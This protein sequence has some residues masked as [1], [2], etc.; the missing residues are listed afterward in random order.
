[1]NTCA[2]LTFGLEPQAMA[3]LHMLAGREP[4]FARWDPEF[5]HYDVRIETF[6]WYNGRERGIALVVHRNYG[7]SGPCLILTFGE[8][9]N[10][11]DIFVEQWEQD[12]APFN[13]PTIENRSDKNA[14][15][16]YYNR[17]VCDFGNIGKAAEHIIEAMAEWYNVEEKPTLKALPA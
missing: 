8:C 14:A 13:C 2:N 11:D 10:S 17:W 7:C 5:K 9:R 16:A 1:M 3:I 12:C 4:S 6:P 15:R